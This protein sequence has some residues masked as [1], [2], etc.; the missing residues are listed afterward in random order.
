MDIAYDQAHDLFVPS[1]DSMK[2]KDSA[3]I[4]QLNESMRQKAKA[5]FCLSTTVEMFADHNCK[6]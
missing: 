4:K 2:K 3:F 6:I 5:V 1:I